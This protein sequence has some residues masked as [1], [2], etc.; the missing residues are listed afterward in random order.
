M[1]RTRDQQRR[2]AFL[3]RVLALAGLAGALQDARADNLH[4]LAAG[5]LREAI[6]EIGDRYKAATGI[7]IA[8]EFGPSGVLRERI[9]K[10][11]KTDLFASADNGMGRLLPNRVSLCG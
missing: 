11:E 9:E 6:G 1:G 7:D 4:V 3:L 2:S 8:A 10:G 5:S